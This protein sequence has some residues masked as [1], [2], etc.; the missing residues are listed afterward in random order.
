MPGGT[1]IDPELAETLRRYA[2]AEPVRA[3][4]A[5]E[6]LAGLLGEAPLDA[7]RL[8]HLDLHLL[9]SLRDGG[10][11][12]LHNARDALSAFLEFAGRADAAGR[13]RHPRWADAERRA[14][15]DPQTLPQLLA[16]LADSPLFPPPLLDFQFG[17]AAGPVER[18]AQL[19]VTDALEQALAAGTTDPSRT[20]GWRRARERIARD[21]LARPVDGAGT[22]RAAVEAERMAAWRQ[23]RSAARREL[24]ERVAPLLA[25]PAS[26]HSE[27]AL[28]AE[29]LMWL[30]DGLE[31]GDSTAG[32]TLA[33]ATARE[34]ST[35]AGWKPP[36]SPRRDPFGS[37]VDA[38][39][40]IA[41]SAGLTT[42][43]DGRLVPSALG[44]RLVQDPRALWQHVCRWGVPARRGSAE[45]FVML[46]VAQPEWADT[47]LMLAAQ[48]V[49][50]GEEYLLFEHGASGV[51]P[52][53]GGALTDL[54]YQ[55]LDQVVNIGL[56]LG[57]V[58][59]SGLKAWG[60]RYRVSP[61]G[62]P[63]L[64]EVL[65]SNAIGPGVPFVL[66]PSSV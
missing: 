10:A 41:A 47:K 28:I 2:D 20:E 19:E 13:C 30:L 27:H 5:Q 24:V 35:R 61:A 54:L 57:A 3:A 18:E 40:Q 43:Q 55:H 7:L 8:V 15:L 58:E 52:A 42:T 21:V 14:E 65:R 23:S 37:P 51:A 60:R 53:R 36:R 9:E 59:V 32:E 25:E 64:R 33:L 34:V 63:T 26:W 16:D 46:L 56:A 49:V 12:Q 62:T 29:R 66:P 17:P 45:V 4:R 48:P 22:V 38:L 1:A 31:E 6:A 39:V 44:R 50:T 11:L